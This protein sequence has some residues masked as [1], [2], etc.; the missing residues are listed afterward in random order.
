MKTQDNPA[1]QPAHRDS[2]A[3]TEARPTRI[4]KPR[5]LRQRATASDS[6][7]RFWTEVHPQT[8]LLLNALRALKNGDFAV[9]LPLDW[10]GTAGKVADTFNEVAL[11]KERTAQEL[12]QLRRAVGDTSVLLNA[13]TALKNGDFSVRL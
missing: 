5:R 10:D 9:R 6:P 1:P 13:L 7:D 11:S 12:A 8:T 4:A 3:R 2:A